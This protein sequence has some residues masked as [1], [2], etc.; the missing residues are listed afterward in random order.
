MKQIDDN[1]LP[2]FFALPTVFSVVVM[3]ALLA[4]LLAI[5]GDIPFWDSLGRGALFIEWV[6]LTS[7]AAL[8]LLRRP[9]T[10][11]PAWAAGLAAWLLV[12]LLTAA[13]AEVAW[14]IL[15]EG[16]HEP[17]LAFDFLLRTTAMGAVV[18][19]L[20][21]RHLYV[22]D[23][24]KRQIRAEAHARLQAFQARIRPHFLFNSLNT[25]AALTRSDPAR[26]ERAVEDLADIFR[27]TLGAPRGFIALEEELETVHRHLEIEGL[28][29]G[30]RLHLEWAVEPAAQEVAMPPLVLQ[31]LV[32][33][34]VYHGIEPRPEGGTIR[35]AARI[36]GDLLRL[37]VANPRNEAA[38]RREGNRMA[39]QN[40]RGRL[41][42]IYGQRARLEVEED[43]KQYRV[44]VEFPT[45]TPR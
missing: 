5:Y 22:R 38:S 9:L 42:M 39:L 40:I 11:L 28:R 13:C 17:L 41:Q 43:Q 24:W 31:P 36:D 18:A 32:E 4:L 34:A 25:V 2:D 6:A 8:G 37:E 16:R 15:H 12:T 21:L 14:L 27:A 33:N 30:E 44:R 7:L 20:A 26:A 35:I 45:E 3:A 23:Q 1:F 10:R 29:L 19:A